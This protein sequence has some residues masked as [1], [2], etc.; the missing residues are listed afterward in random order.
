MVVHFDVK[1]DVCVVRLEGRF[2]TGLDSDYL[3]G[4]VDEL[5]RLASK[6]VVADFSQVSYIDSTGI[7]F[8]ISVYTSITKDG[9]G[10]FVLASPN[11]RVKEVLQLTKLYTILI[12]YP[13]V[14]SAI[15]ALG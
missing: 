14:P 7:G 13:D 4:K 2:A 5:K 15:A 3:R 10:R 11:R 9:N 12:A 6:K 8:L 1:G